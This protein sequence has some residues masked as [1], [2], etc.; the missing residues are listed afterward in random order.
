MVSQRSTKMND[1]WRQ[2]LLWALSYVFIQLCKRNNPLTTSSE[3][4]HCIFNSMVTCPLKIKPYLIRI[5]NC[6]NCSTD[7]FIFSLIYIDKLIAK[8]PK[9]MVTSQNVRCLILTSIVIAV[10]FH[11]DHFYKNS[12]YAQVGGVLCRSLKRLEIL[13]LNEINF[14]LF[15]DNSVYSQSCKSLKKAVLNK[16]LLKLR[17]AKKTSE[18]AGHIQAIGIKLD[19]NNLSYTER[20]IQYTEGAKPVCMPIN[21][22][23]W[24]HNIHHQGGNSCNKI[25]RPQLINLPVRCFGK[26]ISNWQVL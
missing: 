14:E 26:K 16:T 11:E 3:R 24:S 23:L 21:S 20:E 10:K 1:K 17:F 19:P 13:F 9:F 6:T 15:V 4:T 12:F 7:S 25:T 18:G 5:A 22:R 2:H 8:N